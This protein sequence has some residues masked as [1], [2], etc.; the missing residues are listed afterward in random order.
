MRAKPHLSCALPYSQCWDRAQ[1]ICYECFSNKGASER[2]YA[3]RATV[4]DS[5]LQMKNPR[6]GD[7]E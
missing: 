7:I 4:L 6:L 5:I 3:V 2:P 1:Q